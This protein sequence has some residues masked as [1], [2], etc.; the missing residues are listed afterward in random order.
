MAKRRTNALRL[1]RAELLEP[2]R[3]MAVIAVDNTVHDHGNVPGEQDAT[4][5]LIGPHLGRLRTSN[6]S[7]PND[8]SFRGFRSPA[9]EIDEHGRQARSADFNGDGIADL[10]T[11]N[12]GLV[13][14]RLSNE[15]GQLD[16]PLEFS[17]P[18][19]C[20]SDDRFAVGDF[21]S[22][23]IPEIVVI[24]GFLWSVIGFENGAPSMVAHGETG[25]AYASHV[26]THDFNN[27]G[28]LDIVVGGQQFSWNT[29]LLLGNGANGFTEHTI[30]GLGSSEPSVGTRLMSP[31]DVDNDGNV[32]LV[33]ALSSIATNAYD[34][35]LWW[36]RGHGDGSFDAETKLVDGFHARRSFL[37]LNLADLNND[38]MTDIVASD[39][40]H[41][42]EVWSG[43]QNGFQKEPIAMPDLV[44]SVHMT[45]LDTEVAMVAVT[46]DTSDIPKSFV[47][48]LRS[49][50]GYALETHPVQQS[51][52]YSSDQIQIADYTGDGIVDIVANTGRNSNQGGK[53]LILPGTTSPQFTAD[54]GVTFGDEGRIYQ[55]RANL[56]TFDLA[57]VQG[58]SAR[59]DAWIDFDQDGIWS[60]DEQIFEA[61]ETSTTL[62]IENA[63]F[64]VPPNAKHGPTHARIRIST[65]GGLDPGDAALDGEVEDYLVE[66]I[67]AT[68]MDFGDAPT[69][70]QS[71]QFAGYP[72][73]V[74]DNGARHLIGGPRFGDT[75]APEADGTPDI[76][77]DF[78][79]MQDPTL[80]IEVSD[81]VVGQPGQISFDVQGQDGYVNAWIDYN[82]DGIWNDA[83]E[84]I[85]VDELVPAGTTETFSFSLFNY[86]AGQ[87]SFIRARVAGTPGLG[88]T[89]LAVDGEVDDLKVSVAAGVAA[90]QPVE[91]VVGPGVDQL[92]VYAGETPVRTTLHLNRMPTETLTVGLSSTDESLLVPS[93][94]EIVF[95]QHNWDQPQPI[96]WTALANDLLLEDRQVFARYTRPD[97]DSSD[98]IVTVWPVAVRV[99]QTNELPGL[100][101]ITL[102]SSETLPLK[103]PWQTEMPIG[104]DGVFYRQVRYGLQTVL[105]GGGSQWQNPLVPYDVNAD[106]RVSSVDALQIINQMG[107]RSSLDT[108]DAGL[109]DPLLAL[110]RFRYYDVTGDGRLTALD[111]L[112]IINFQGR[113]SQVGSGERL[114]VT[115]A[116]SRPDDDRF[117]VELID[118]LL[119]QLF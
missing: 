58:A 57:G 98:D 108:N 20:S 118:R 30:S 106:Q 88:P 31:G 93:V 92:I 52:P 1:A 42:I 5:L 71:G 28:H 27:D 55:G 110:D 95:D 82:R 69:A 14:I 63:S 33:F 34:D 84:H 115:D 6:L 107:R 44:L 9:A 13:R 41:E 70:A 64:D 19:A 32:D 89:G 66:V 61:F 18:N 90:D 8:G 81:L 40:G 12:A 51:I 23:G 76:N 49:S 11:N 10:A 119:A 60:V 39:Y 59:I 68:D 75:V 3:L 29:T 53:V 111:A 24:C 46:Q 47:H 22:D 62:S 87:E 2:R 117:D 45:R 54:D 25:V 43:S 67:A 105:I 78:E 104:R 36:M 86:L 109:G 101:E 16:P 17:H 74:A 85:V 56:I 83:E 102:E 4:H 114:W 94:S 15:A 38:G 97:P 73:T 26:Q 80:G 65:Q 35:G 72:V 96:S 91:L 37:S 116:Q 112:Q 77:A 100:H 21:T 7:G 113:N 99:R 50:T 103:S 48:V 79:E